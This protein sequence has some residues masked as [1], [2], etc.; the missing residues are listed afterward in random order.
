MNSLR[1]Q[2]YDQILLSISPHHCPR[3]ACVPERIR[4]KVVS[5]RRISL[6]GH[7]VPTQ[8]PSVII[9]KSVLA[10]GESQYGSL[11]IDASAVRMKAFSEMYL[12]VGLKISDH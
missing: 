12:H 4:R 7:S 8:S 5:A 3:V 9:G 1:Q 2:H 11:V 10:P 6:D